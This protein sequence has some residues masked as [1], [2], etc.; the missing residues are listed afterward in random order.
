MILK[1]I[2]L[3]VTGGCGFI[4]SNFCN[5][6]CDKVNKLVIIDKITYAGNKD[7]IKNILNKN[8]VILIEEDIIYHNFQKTYEKYNINYIVHLAGETHV[9]KS[10]SCLN[11][12]IN[13]NITATHILLESLKINKIP[14]IFFST[15]EIYGESN[16]NKFLESDHYNPTNPY[17]AT[18]AAAELLINSYIKSYNINIIIVRC[19]N[20][21]GLNQHNEKVIP[22]FINSALN[23]KSLKIHGSGNKIRDFVYIDDIIDAIIILMNNGVNNEIYNIG[24][25]NPISILELANLILNITKSNSKLEYIDDRPFNDNRYNINNDKISELGWKPKHLTKE[26]FINNIIY[27]INNKYDN[28]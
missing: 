9:D 11:N 28:N 2:N 18:K 27:L 3:L 12:F 23:N 26:S 8:N 1:N 13:N 22:C 21:Y 24:Y 4:G 5:F 16:N 19:N 25:E 7:N 6:I 10:Y 14:I 20:V 15:D 17:A